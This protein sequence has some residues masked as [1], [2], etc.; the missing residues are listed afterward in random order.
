ME[1]FIDILD[2]YNSFIQ[3]MLSLNYEIGGYISL[4]ENTFAITARSDVDTPLLKVRNYPYDPSIGKIDWHTHYKSIFPSDG[5]PVDAPRLIPSDT[6]IMSLTRTSFRYQVPCVSVVLSQW[7]YFFFAPTEK[8]LRNKTLNLKKMLNEIEYTNHDF[9]MKHKN[10][11]LE[12]RVNA[13]IKALARI[14]IG[15]A[16]VY[17]YF[18]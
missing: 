13:Y 3:K 10:W 2:R 12:R 7:G 6:D 9:F 14:G 4:S 1:L 5:L 17:R 8:L 16:M 18:I 11:S 15:G